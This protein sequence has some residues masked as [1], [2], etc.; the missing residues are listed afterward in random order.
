MANTSAQ[1]ERGREG[2]FINQSLLALSTIIQRLSEEKAGGAKQHIPYRDSK[3]TRYKY[4]PIG[5]IVCGRVIIAVA[6]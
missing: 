5:H 3:L 2:K 4:T 1:G 6:H